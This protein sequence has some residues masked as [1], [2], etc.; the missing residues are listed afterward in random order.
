MPLT[1]Q[2]VPTL[3]LLHG[4]SL[5]QSPAEKHQNYVLDHV[6]CPP[7][8]S[9]DTPRQPGLLQSCSALGAPAG[10][11][12]PAHAGRKH[13]VQKAASSAV[14]TVKAPHLDLMFGFRLRRHCW[15]AESGLSPDTQRR[16]EFGGLEDAQ[17]S[18]D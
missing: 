12:R 13:R 3:Q 5:A 2:D 11:P 1:L 7:S 15:F 9:A 18:R 10:A 8:S 14:R 4:R 6:Y 16:K 17:R